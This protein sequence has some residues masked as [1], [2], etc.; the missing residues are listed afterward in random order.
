LEITYFNEE[1]KK[2]P[3][4]KSFKKEK[5]L[6]PQPYSVYVSRPGLEILKNDLID[7]SKKYTEYA[8]ALP[9]EEDFKHSLQQ[10]VRLLDMGFED[11]TTPIM[12]KNGTLLLTYPKCHLVAYT[13]ELE[14]VSFKIKVNGHIDRMFSKSGMNQSRFRMIEPIVDKR[15]YQKALIE[16]EKI[17]YD[18][19]F[20]YGKWFIPEID[21]HLREWFK[22]HNTNHNDKVN[23]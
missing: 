18:M 21:M 16:V 8:K 14:D 10:Y 1:V 9:R 2:Y 5:Q 17:V 12:E 13:K 23:Q 6:L 7:Y 20:K 3:F 4:K 11:H 19:V 15:G 22:K